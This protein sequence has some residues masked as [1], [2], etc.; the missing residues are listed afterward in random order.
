MH[1]SV[2]ER[3]RCKNHLRGS[4]FETQSSPYSPYNHGSTVRLISFRK[5]CR[6]LVRRFYNERCHTVLKYAQPFNRI[7]NHP[8]FINISGTVRLHSRRPYCRPFGAIEHSELDSSFIGHNSHHST[9]RVDLA[10]NLPLGDTAYSR[11][12]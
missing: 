12:A 4:E 10:H 6:A 8:P 3:T 1:Q 7:E 2:K 5:F 11:I 9:E